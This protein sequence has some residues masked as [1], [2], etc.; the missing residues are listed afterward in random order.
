MLTEVIPDLAKIGFD[1]APFGK[2]TFV[3]QGVPSDMPGGEEKNILDEVLDQLK[4]ESNDA[5]ANRTEKLLVHMARRLSINKHAVQ[6]PEGQQALIDEL[7]GCTQP[8]YTPN[9]KR[10]FTMIRR[11]ELDD[12]LG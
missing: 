2:N 7:F 5:V 1:I 10:V 6:Q 3:V 12:M 9:G 8:E 11:E 4:H